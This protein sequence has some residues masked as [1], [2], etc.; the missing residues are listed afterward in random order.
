MT[1]LLRRIREMTEDVGLDR[2]RPILVAVRVPAS[3]PF[4]EAAGLDVKRWLEDGLVDL[5][6]PGELELS[7]WEEM[8]TLGHSHNVSVYPCLSWTGSKKRKGPPEVQS[9]L[10]RR[11]FRARAMNIWHAGADGVYSFNLPDGLDPANSIWRE[12]GDPQTLASL[13][14]DYFPHGYWRALLGNDFRDMR[15]FVKAPLP[16]F[17]EGP[18]TLEL[19]QPHEV[20]VTIGEDLTGEGHPPVKVTLS[21][22]TTSPVNANALAVTLN[23]HPL[24]DPIVK[25][26]WVSFVVA[27]QWLHDGDNAIRI[28]N[29][30]QTGNAII[31]RDVHVGIANSSVS[32]RPTGARR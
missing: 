12:L 6:V 2:G 23:D 16:P 7:P 27:S 13:D 9:D 10:P 30:D 25:D 24:T 26:S 1:D 21:L 15:R 19:G 17:P 3:V 11:S 14:K 28:T 18:V 31:L 4:C 29:Q 22:N 20:T 5:L 32:V 8:V